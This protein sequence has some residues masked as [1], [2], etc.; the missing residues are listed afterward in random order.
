MFKADNMVNL[1]PIVE[2]MTNTKNQS[3]LAALIRGNTPVSLVGV[4]AAATVVPEYLK[5]VGLQVENFQI[6]VQ[7]DTGDVYSYGE[8]GGLQV[9][10]ELNQNHFVNSV[11]EID[12]NDCFFHALRDQL[13]ELSSISIKEL[14]SLIANKIESDPKLKSFIESGSHRLSMQR[15]AFG[16]GIDATNFPKAQ[17]YLNGLRNA[18]KYINTT[19]GIYSELEKIFTGRAGLIELDHIPP[20]S[21]Y[22]DSHDFKNSPRKMPVVAVLYEVHRAMESTGNKNSTSLAD[23]PGFDKSKYNKEFLKYSLESKRWKEVIEMGILD[24]H[25]VCIEKKVKFDKNGMLLLVGEHRNLGHI[26]ATE[27]AALK[28]IINGLK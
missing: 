8:H 26:K 23:V 3:L 10:L 7:A 16:G 13:P 19:G 12:G 20:S 17:T 27:E 11:N 15:G 24:N 1:R 9:D 6:N 28:T 21:A 2:L 18:G 4:Q 5:L 25:D 22:P 14:R